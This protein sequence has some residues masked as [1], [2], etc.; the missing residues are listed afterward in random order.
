MKADQ[1][2]LDDSQFFINLNCNYEA[3]NA[4]GFLKR[5]CAYSATTPGGFECVGSF[6]RAPDGTWNASIN[7]VYDP[8][9]DSDACVVAE[10]SSRIDAIA[11]LWRERH[12]VHFGHS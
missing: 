2:I 12:R 7:T 1:I 8:E 5:R 3:A 9:A 11:A 6:D 4:P 10:G